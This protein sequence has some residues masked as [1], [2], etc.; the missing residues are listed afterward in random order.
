MRSTRRVAAKIVRK[1]VPSAIE[2]IRPGW[3]LI[4]YDLPVA[5]RSTFFALGLARARSMSISA[6]RS[7]RFL[8]D[9]DGRLHGAHLKLKKVRYLTF[10]PE[11]PSRR[12]ARNRVHRAGGGDSF[13][14][15]R[16]AP[17]TGVLATG[18]LGN[19]VMRIATWNVNSLKARMD[20]VIGW[21]DRAQTGRAPDA[22]D[23]AGRRGRA[24]HAVPRGAAT[25]WPTTAKAAGTASRLHPLPIDGE[26]IVTNFG[27]GRCAIRA[28]VP[29]ADLGE[30][31][32][33]RSTK[34]GCLS[35]VIDGVALRLHLRAQRPGGRTRRSTRASS[36]GT[37]A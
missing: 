35:V 23:Q 31:D 2:R 13:N 34:R 22:G 17:A 7:G 4:G 19:A 3:K 1:S 11:D 12:G 29:T 28:P 24:G 5:K 15:A 8:S 6:G 21:L 27:E 25:S 37:T 30:E 10:A 18:E 36:P 16:R 33:N 20:R 32:F 26:S 14:V 9:P